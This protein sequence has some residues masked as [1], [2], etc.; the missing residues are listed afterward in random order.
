MID[1]YL[2]FIWSL[3]FSVPL[4]NCTDC[5]SGIPQTYNLLIKIRHCLY[6]LVLQTIFSSH[7]L[8]TTLSENNQSSIGEVLCSL[9][10]QATNSY[11]TTTIMTCK[12]RGTYATIPEMPELASEVTEYQR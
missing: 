1:Y 8:Y 3:L 7:T 4:E 12:A 9:A 11:V 5:Y 2:C 10:F 6:H